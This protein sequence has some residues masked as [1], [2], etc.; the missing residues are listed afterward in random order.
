MTK[1]LVMTKVLE[2]KKAAY[3]MYCHCDLSG[4]LPP[5]CFCLQR[6]ASLCLVPRTT[7][8]LG[9]KHSRCSTVSNLLKIVHPDSV[10][11]WCLCRKR[12]WDGGRVFVC[13]CKHTCSC[14]SQQMTVCYASICGCGCYSTF[15][16][17][18]E[19]QIQ[20]SSTSTQMAVCFMLLTPSVSNS[21]LSHTV[22]IRDQK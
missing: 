21:C 2:L 16:Q 18:G 8:M 4:F 10:G 20:P 13:L 14:H 22:A 6:L 9:R 19:K 15:T 1:S 17:R 7:D 12:Q 11:W 5:L 3:R